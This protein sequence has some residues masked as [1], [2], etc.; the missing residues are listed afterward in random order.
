[1]TYYILELPNC[2]WKFHRDPDS[3]SRA[4]QEEKKK[5]KKFVLANCCAYI[6]LVCFSPEIFIALNLGPK[7]RRKTDFKISCSCCNSLSEKQ[8]R[9]TR[10]FP[11]Q[12][13]KKLFS[14]LGF[15]P[16]AL[17]KR[18]KIDMQQ[19]QQPVCCWQP[20]RSLGSSAS[21]SDQL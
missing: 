14:F 12:L 10:W 4:L 15:Q 2:L 17:V 6:K 8:F 21:S 19:Q 16:D 3:F 20:E 9:P 11:H 7:M 18:K 5:K 1:M 13:P